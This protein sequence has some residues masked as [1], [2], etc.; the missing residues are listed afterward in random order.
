MKRIHSI[1]FM[2]GLVMIIMALDHVRDMMH[3]NSITQ[4]PTDL[5][6]TTP[7]LFFTRGSR[8]Y[9]HLYLFSWPVPL[10]IYLLR[11]KITARKAGTFYLKEASGYYC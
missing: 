11:I 10:L 4:S 7:T 3:I 6:T 5:S 2:R 1:D 9:V 8:I